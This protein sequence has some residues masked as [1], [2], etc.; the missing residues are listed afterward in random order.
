MSPATGPMIVS[1]IPDV[2]TFLALRRAVNMDPFTH[3]A[4]MEGLG[5]T[6]FGVVASDGPEVV[7]MG[8]LIGDGGCFVQVVD[9]MVLPAYQ[10]RGLGKQIVG[11]LMEFV[12]TSLPSSVYVSLMA[13]VPADDLYAQFGFR[14]TAPETVGMAL[15]KA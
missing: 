12:E 4:A 1:G 3:E 7:G 5:G 14:H 10:G 6:L 9:I 2:E 11:A 8:R 15:K 13:D